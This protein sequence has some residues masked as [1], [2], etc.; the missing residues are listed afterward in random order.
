MEN[1][2]TI[3][4][5]IVTYNRK[6]LLPE[7]LKGIE[8][9][10]H[11]VDHILIIDNASTD[12]TE[13]LQDQFVLDNRISYIRLDENLGSAGGFAFG[14]TEAHKNGADWIWF[15]DDD[16]SPESDCL[17]KML[18]YQDISKCIHPSKKDSKGVEFFW[19][20]IFDPSTAKATFLPNLSFRNGKE[21]VGVNLGCFEGMLIHRSIVDRIGVPDKR[22]FIAGDDTIYG[23][24]A[25]LHTTVIFVRDAHIKKLI[26]FNPILSPRFVYYAVRN[27]LLIKDHLKRLNVLN[28]KLFFLHYWLFVLYVCTKHTVR[29][30]SLKIFWYALRGVYDGLCGNYGRVA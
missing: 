23:F 15:L 28:K 19:E 9:Q 26:A 7:C 2:S 12:G 30:R 4:A 18:I 25:S 1:K 17:E 20:G 27:Q 11:R 22:F 13:L 3:T 5:V 10:T 16:V 14:V 21:Y 8:Q 24:E 29:S 6:G